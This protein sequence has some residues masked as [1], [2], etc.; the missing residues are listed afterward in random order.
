MQ[1]VFIDNVGGKCMICLLFP[2]NSS[3]STMTDE[4]KTEVTNRKIKRDISRHSTESK[5]NDF[6]ISNVCLE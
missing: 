2:K 4:V 6:I 3:T 5:E 1:P